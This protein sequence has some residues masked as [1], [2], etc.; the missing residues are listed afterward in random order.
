MD[1]LPSFDDAWGQVGTDRNERHILLGNGFSIGAHP[2]FGYDRLYEVAKTKGIPYRSEQLFDR[3]GTNNFEMV[4]NQLHES[5]WLAE[6][7]GLGASEIH[8]DHEAVKRALID[9]IATV[10]PDNLALLDYDDIE[11]IGEFLRKFK[12]IATTNYDLILYW[13]LNV[14]ME[15][16]HLNRYSFQDGFGTARGDAGGDLHFFGVPSS[17]A[18]IVCYLHGGLHLARIHGTVRKR[19]WGFES[20]S[21]IEQARTAISNDQPPLF[22]SEGRKENKEGQIESNGYLTWALQQLRQLKGTIFTYG[23]ALLDQ[24]GHLTQAIC[25]NRE[26]SNL[27]VGVYDDPRSSGG[28][29]LQAR[30]QRLSEVSTVSR[31]RGRKPGKPI[32][33]RFYDAKSLELWSR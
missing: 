18:R 21:L 20:G 26:I 7:Y 12:I 33:V 15:E 30:A 29:E 14:F 13:I 23:W 6:R 8:A 2:D 24:D 5:A 32:N 31:A 16:I 22:V 1:A 9:A 4:L 10:H 3:Y 11:R 25:A 19:R 27:W 28:L 17:A